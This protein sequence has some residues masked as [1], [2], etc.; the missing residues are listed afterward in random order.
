MDYRLISADDHLDLQYLITHTLKPS[1]LFR[2]QVWVSFQDDLVAM[3]L[4][5][6][7]GEGRLMWASDYPN[8]DSIWP[9]SRRIVDKQMGELSPAVRRQLTRDNAAALYGL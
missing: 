2:R 6:F 3:S 1:E 7:Y 9:N 8:P 5:P 4:L